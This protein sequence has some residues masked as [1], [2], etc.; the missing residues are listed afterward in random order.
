M[1]EADLRVSTPDYFRT[2]GIPFLTG[3]NFSEHD[4]NDSLPIAIIN[5][6]TAAS[7]SREGPDRQVLD[8]FRTEERQSCR[9]SE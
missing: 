2:M 6:A 5:Q 9:L 8:E 3:R 1:L 4:V 7:L